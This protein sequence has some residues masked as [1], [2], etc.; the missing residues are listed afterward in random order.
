MQSRE[1]TYSLPVRV[2]KDTD[3]VGDNLEKTLYLN[4]P[5][6]E[7]P[8]EGTVSQLAIGRYAPENEEEE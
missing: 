3:A 8:S 4:R 5:D 1:L 7:G 6:A 2:Q